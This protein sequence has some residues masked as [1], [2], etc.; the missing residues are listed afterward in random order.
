MPA[1]TIKSTQITNLD[2]TNPPLRTSHGAM[3]VQKQIASVAVSGTATSPSTYQMCRIP[4]DAIITSIQGWLDAANTTFTADLTLY[5]S[6]AGV[7]DGTN[8]LN[9]GAVAAHVF[10]TAK[11]MAAIVTATELFLGGNVTGAGN[12]GQPAWKVAGLTSDPGGYFD[13][14]WVTTATNSG[15]AQ[16]NTIVEY[17]AS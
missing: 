6:T 9:T 5:Y 13:V 1:E 8:F 11:A 7:Y 3:Y 4:S 17:H 14:T 15:A 16:L 12:L 10:Q 2:K